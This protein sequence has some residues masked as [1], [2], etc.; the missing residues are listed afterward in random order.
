MVAGGESTGGSITLSGKWSASQPAKCRRS[1]PGRAAARLI[2]AI[3]PGIV[4]EAWYSVT[5]SA[6]RPSTSVAI[7][8]R[9]TR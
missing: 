4:R 5:T 1:G 8:G 9:K 7:V 6:G 3:R 2:A